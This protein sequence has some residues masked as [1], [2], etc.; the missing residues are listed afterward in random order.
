MRTIAIAAV[1]ALVLPSC[2]STAPRVQEVLV[3]IPI[4][5]KV[6]IPNRPA[7][8]VEQ[9]PIGL[10]IWEQMKALRAERNQRQGYETELEAAV[11]SCQESTENARIEAASVQYIPR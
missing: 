11:K 6:A 8:A 7:F 4:P 10:G 5:C 9:L 3:P 1:M 2:V